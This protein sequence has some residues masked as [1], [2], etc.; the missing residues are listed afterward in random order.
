MTVITEK[1]TVISEIMK[2]QYYLKE[3]VN[4][5]KDIKNQLEDLKDSY[6]TREFNFGGLK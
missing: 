6:D 3:Q 2:T 1:E 5:L 4:N